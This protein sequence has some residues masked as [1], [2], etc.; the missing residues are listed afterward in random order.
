MGLQILH[1]VVEKGK[2][3]NAICRF[4]G[5]DRKP[6][7]NHFCAA[8][9]S[10]YRAGTIDAEGRVLKPQIRY[11]RDFECVVHRCGLRGKIVRGLCQKHYQQY[12]TGAIDALGCKL[13]E[14]KRLLYGPDSICR[15]ERCGR[16]PKAKGWC[17]AHREA[18]SKGQYNSEGKRLVPGLKR[19]LGHL[20]AYTGGC[21]KPAHCKGLCRLHYQRK[22]T[23]YLGPLGHKNVGQKCSESGCGKPAHCRTLCVRHYF[24]LRRVE[25]GQ[26]QT[27]REKSG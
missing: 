26:T 3:R 18:Y 17:T 6:R 4:Q 2:Y 13:R 12:R 20:C 19:N 25:K 23:G 14:P 8:H 24:Q 1:P 15:A 16:R 5:C 11:P 10:R 7:R 9:S 22:I 21:G 27:Q